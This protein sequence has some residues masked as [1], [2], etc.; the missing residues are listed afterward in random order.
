MDTLFILN[1]Y[2]TLNNFFSI[3]SFQMRVLL[4]LSR[5]PSKR[6]GMH[7]AG[8][9]GSMTASP[10]GPNICVPFCFMYVCT[11]HKAADALWYALAG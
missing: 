2:M 9:N 10:A 4:A 7:Q 8:T 11:A 5:C 3:L 1:C 6:A